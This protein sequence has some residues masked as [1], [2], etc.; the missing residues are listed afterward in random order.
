MIHTYICELLLL[1]FVQVQD[2]VKAYLEQGGYYSASKHLTQ[3]FAKVFRLSAYL[4]EK[5]FIVERGGY[6]NIAGCFKS[7]QPEITCRLQGRKIINPSGGYPPDLDAHWP[8]T[9]GDPV[10][11]RRISHGEIYDFPA[12]LLKSLSFAV[13]TYYLFT[14]NIDSFFQMSLL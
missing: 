12:L 10:D 13:A 9:G 2:Q 5:E 6:L 7:L 14:I 8:Q 11:I 3:M 1:L 4:V